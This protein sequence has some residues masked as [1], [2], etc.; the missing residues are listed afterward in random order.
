MARCNVDTFHQIS[1]IE[2]STAGIIQNPPAGA[3]DAAEYLLSADLGAVDARRPSALDVETARQAAGLTQAAAAALLGVPVGTWSTWASG[4][5]V[6]PFWRWVCFGLRTRRAV[7]PAGGLGVPDAVTV[8]EVRLIS[9]VALADAA[10]MVHLRAA[11]DWELFE[12]SD[13]SVPIPA[14][15]WDLFLLRAARMALPVPVVVDLRAARQAAGLTQAA[16]A[17]LVYA[18]RETWA[19]WESSGPGGRQIPAARLDLFALKAAAMFDARSL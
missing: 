4:E 15:L 2:S 9:G 11:A 12:R 17:A 3:V 7:I 16:A 6:M 10:A 19:A 18:T 14:H 8:R 1:A 13:M 5:A